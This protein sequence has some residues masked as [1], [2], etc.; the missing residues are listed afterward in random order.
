MLRLGI[1]RERRML[2][3]F[4]GSGPLEQ[5]PSFFLS[6]VGADCHCSLVP[7]S[8]HGMLWQMFRSLDSVSHTIV[9]VTAYY[10]ECPCLCSDMMNDSFHGIL[11]PV[12]VLSFG[13]GLVT[14]FFRFEYS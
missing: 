5:V 13:R 7:L 10:K 3:E 2:F 1:R 11:F 14:P 6:L 9:A 12:L 4:V 8:I